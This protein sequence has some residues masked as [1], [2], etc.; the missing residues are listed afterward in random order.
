[1]SQT[2]RFYSPHTEGSH[3]KDFNT[4]DEAL[5]YASESDDSVAQTQVSKP[6]E[7]FWCTELQCFLPKESA[8]KILINAQQNG[9]L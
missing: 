7:C 5:T 1:M 2:Y 6:M 9:Q 4:D 3:T 8:E